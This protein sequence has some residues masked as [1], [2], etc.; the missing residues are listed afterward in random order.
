MPLNH[1]DRYDPMKT[2]V[3]VLVISMITGDYLG[4]LQ[5]QE[6][7]AQQRDFNVEFLSNRQIQFPEEV[8]DQYQRYSDIWGYTSENGT[9]FAILGTGIGT[10]IYELSDPANPTLVS[11]VPGTLSR[12][13]DFKTYGHYIFGVADEGADGLLIINMADAPDNIQWSFWRPT[14]TIGSD[15]PRTLD[16]CHNLY[17]DSTFVF[18][19]GCNLHGG[20]ILILD[21][22]TDPEQPDFIA[23]GDRRYAHDV[24]VQN[25]RMY[26][27]DLGS[28]CVIVDITDINNPQTIVSQETSLDFT[29]NA[30]VS[31]DGSFLFTTDER[32]DAF[33]DAYDIRNT[34]EILRLDQYQPS[35]TVRNPV[36]PHNVHY[37]NGYLI[38]SYYVDG[39]KIVDAHQPD[40]LVEVGSYDTYRFRDDGFHGA[41][42]AFPFLPSGLILVSDIE[43]G[44]YVL[45]PNYQRAAYLT[46]TITDLTNSD[47]LSDVNIEV[48]SEKPSL[49]KSLQNGLY[50]TGWAGSGNVKITFSKSGYHP[51][52][53]EINLVQ[54]ETMTLDVQLQPLERYEV[55]G[56]VL[57]RSTGLPVAKAQVIVFNDLYEERTTANENGMFTISSFEGSV[58]IAAGH[59]GYIHSFILQDLEE[60]KN[61]VTLELDKGYRDDFVFDF[62]WTVANSSGTATIQ[63]WQKG[64]PK[65]AIYN[66]EITNP[67]GDLEQ[68][69]GN[70]CFVTGLAGNLGA[71]LSDTSTLIS[72]LFDI[73]EYTDPVIN[74][75]TWFYDF[76]VQPADDQLQILIGD[77]NQEVLVES[78]NMSQSG[79]R[80][81]SEIRV[82]DFI[83]PTDGMY[84]KIVAADTG[85]VHIYEAAVDAFSISEGQTTSALESGG[86]SHILVFPNPVKSILNIQTQ[87]VKID[88]IV[89][90]DM[91]GKMVLRKSFANT[92]FIEIA[93]LRPGS[94]VLLLKYQG[95]NLTTKKFIKG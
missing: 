21:L 92:G 86:T 26:T 95:K 78:I 16:K 23:T 60:D 63:G 37:L 53:V 55:S 74:Y 17:I 68:D 73:S 61:D 4:L 88:E 18:L 34:D 51:E 69:F 59:W 40:N 67:N 54:E 44:L 36:I 52:I 56:Q 43:S 71:N 10:A 39:V 48:E 81:R 84:L 15:Q 93:T 66:E 20:G 22:S 41:W 76:G 45:R 3:V 75:N 80:D 27:S 28:G 11:L 47:V 38:I 62:G 46:G 12:W 14:L 1:Y 33:I 87:E 31:E 94:Y 13:R 58:T 30:W 64:N 32:T 24:F 89:I 5:A 49:T 7:I 8:N 25:N 83:T 42:G 35:A 29:H 65:Y 90:Y 82:L 77:G 2:V 79:W 85:N 70:E 6:P 91:E 9:E 19:A 50:K 72:P 57:D